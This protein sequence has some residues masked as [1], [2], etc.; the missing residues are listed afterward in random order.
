MKRLLGVP[1]LFAVA[2]SAVGFSLYFSIGVVAKFG[3]G[4]TPLIFLGAGLLFVLTTFTYVEGGAMFL[5]RGGSS[6]LARNAFNELISFVA[7]WAVLIDYIIIVAIAAISV[8]HYLTPISESFGHSGGEIIAA[9]VVIL[10]VTLVNVIG[11]TGQARQR[12]LVVLALADLGLQLAVIA[13]GAMVALDPELLTAQLDLF[14]SPTFS[15]V[16]YAGVIATVAL[17]GIEAASDLAPD[18]EWDPGD[19]RRV[20]NVGAAVVPLLYAAM[21]AVALM[22]VPVVAGPDGPET[23]L[24]GPYIEEPV[25]GVVQSFDP[26]WLADAMQWAVVVIAPTV[27]IW[28]ASISMLGLSRH[29]YTLATNRQI[30]SWLGK[31]GRRTGTPFVAIWTAAAIAL[32]LTLPADVEVLAGLY[33]FGITLAIAIAHLSVIRLRFNDPDR[34]RPYV[35]PFNVS[36]RNRSLPIP[37]LI[38]AVVAVAAWASVVVLHDEARYLGGGWMLF[39]LVAYIVYRRLVEGTSLTRRVAVPA[40]ALTKRTPEVEYGNILVP[41]F[42]TELDDDIVGTAGRLAD[43]AD[44]PGESAP[45]LD[46]IYVMDLPLTVPLDA[47]PPPDRVEAARRALDRAKDVGEEYETVEVATDVVRA[48]S[49]GAGIVEEARR[50]DVEMIVMGGEPPTRVRGGAVLGG[51][52]AAKPAEIGPVTE[53]VLKK[54]PCRVLLTAPPEA[55]GGDDSVE[56]PD[57]DLHEGELHERHHS[58]G[59]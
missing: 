36:V 42:G 27:L 12:L 4:L 31:L 38:G 1:W 19:L 15:D 7:G 21:T 49:V 59:S 33:A 43:A 29:V 2:Y 28:A 25:L 14:S 8:P 18:L 57:E 22:A 10:G 30:P 58:R 17:A 37:A 23:A 13:V 53:Y 26:G 41:V 32:G 3:L 11:L 45:R 56:D 54:A 5:Q 40:E 48:R 6:T 44:E 46:V 9:A 39:G 16:V 47:P 34:E 55:P 50:R 51:I 52:G 35:M 24:A 20:V